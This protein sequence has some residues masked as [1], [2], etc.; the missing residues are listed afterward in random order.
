MWPLSIYMS[1][2][3]FFKDC[4]EGGERG[5]VYRFPGIMIYYSCDE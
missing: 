5:C 2:R 4:E 1:L 3:I